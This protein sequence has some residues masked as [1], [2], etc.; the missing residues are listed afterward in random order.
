[1]NRP[2]LV[3]GLG[4]RDRGDDAVGPVVAG[5]VS[6]AAS[7][8]VT[9]TE[10]EDPTA[11]LD[12][13]EGYDLVVVVD[14]VRS[15]RPPGT[16][17]TWDI[18]TTPVSDDVWSATGRGGTHAFGLATAVELARALHRLPPRVVV[19]GVE[20]RCFDVGA[21]LSGE[22]AAAVDD[23]VAL[24]CTLVEEVGAHVPGRAG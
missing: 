2:V 24:V 9:V 16:V 11:L 8:R 17:R 22:V 23:A 3:V 6:A 19:V 7:P 21:T 15:G 10:H 13:W 20:G 4:S 18:G 5:T 14:A 1:M 12:V